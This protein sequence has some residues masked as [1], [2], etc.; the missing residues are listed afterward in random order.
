VTSGA[1][2]FSAST[3]NLESWF[4]DTSSGLFAFTPAGRAYVYSRLGAADS[5]EVTYWRTNWYTWVISGMLLAIAFVLSRTSWENRLTFVLLVA[6]GGSMWAL[7]DADQTL[8]IV[9]AA[10]WGILAGAAYWFI[11]ALNRPRQAFVRTTSLASGPSTAAPTSP[12][13]IPPPSEPQPPQ[14][15]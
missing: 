6:F 3:A 15:S 13:V 4:N 9:A 8:N 14:Q 5:I 2:G 7:R 11:H 1:V 12:A 10:R